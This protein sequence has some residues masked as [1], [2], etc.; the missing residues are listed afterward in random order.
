MT[1]QPAGDRIDRPPPPR[2]AV[3]ASELDPRGELLRRLA[4]ALR[5]QLPGRKIALPGYCHPLTGTNYR[6]GDPA[7][8]H[9]YPPKSMEELDDLAGS[10][11]HWTCSRCGLVRCYEL[12]D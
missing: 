12:Y 7:C 4:V 11:V 9:D 2:T 1:T 8:D 3:G 5:R 10:C 6:N